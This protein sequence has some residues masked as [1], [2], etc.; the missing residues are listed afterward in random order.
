M[1][2][3]E[4]LLVIMD[5]LDPAR[6]ALAR[7]ILLARHFGASLELFL[8]DTQ[9]AYEFDHAY[10]GSGVAA[11]RAANLQA[12]QCYL[13]STRRSMA[14][15]VAVTVHAAC[16]SPL[17]EA[18]AR[19]VLATG[20]DLVIK[21]VTGM[22]RAAALDSDDWQ[23][24]RTCPA[25]LLL[26]HGR[27][28]HA[29]PHFAVFARSTKAC[30]GRAVD[31]ATFL[32]RGVNARLDVLATDNPAPEHCDLVVVASDP[33]PRAGSIAYRPLDTGLMAALACD[34]LLIDENSAAPMSCCQDQAGVAV[35][36]ASL[37]AH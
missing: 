26:T 32:A 13:E 37:G 1:P 14:A 31:T 5:L 36:E 7:A 12:S 6:L 34:I 19:R 27:P 8:C 22:G 15:D 20:P 29:R 18:V 23:L 25:P 17:C 10:D 33:A 35:H 4:N 21:A 30:A 9:A 3:L 11:A 2:K 28:W 16:E 24:A